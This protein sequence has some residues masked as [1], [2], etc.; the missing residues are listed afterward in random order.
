MELLNVV[1]RVN[2]FFPSE[3]KNGFIVTKQNACNYLPMSNR[4]PPLATVLNHFVWAENC[5]LG[6]TGSLVTRIREIPRRVI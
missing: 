6:T 5:I 4:V 1:N 2:V 3:K